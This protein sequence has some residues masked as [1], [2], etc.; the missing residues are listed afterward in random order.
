MLTALLL[1]SACT[2]ADPVPTPEAG[3]LTVVYGSRGEGEIE[4]C[5]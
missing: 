3:T 5:G 1:L 2:G 4:P